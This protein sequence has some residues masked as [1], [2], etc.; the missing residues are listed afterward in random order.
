MILKVYLTTLLLLV[1]ALLIAV[2]ISAYS[3]DETLTNKADKVGPI[4]I[5]ALLSW[6]IGGVLTAIWVYLE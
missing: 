5:T 6:L 4:L 1:V 3:D 2:H